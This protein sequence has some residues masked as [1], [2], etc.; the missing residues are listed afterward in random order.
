M[1][2]QEGRSQEVVLEQR[3][4]FAEGAKEGKGLRDLV[5]VFKRA[6]GMEIPGKFRVISPQ[7]MHGI[8]GVGETFGALTQILGF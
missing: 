8:Y 4:V 2:D 1:W 3:H 7:L 5:N 6:F